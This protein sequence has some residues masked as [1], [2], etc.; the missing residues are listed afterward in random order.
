[1]GLACFFL[2]LFLMRGGLSRLGVG[3][4]HQGVFNGWDGNS[5]FDYLLRFGGLSSY[6]EGPVISSQFFSVWKYTWK[7]CIQDIHNGGDEIITTLFLSANLRIPINQ[8]GFHGFLS[9]LMSSFL[10]KPGFFVEVFL[11]PRLQW[12]VASHLQVTRCDKQKTSKT[13]HDDPWFFGL[14]LGGLILKEC[15]FFGDYYKGYTSKWEFG[16]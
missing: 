2:V 9:L 13:C 15:D 1:M 12:H 14:L 5:S 8:P 7:W 10:Q 3:R 6:F 4:F 11:L 16:E